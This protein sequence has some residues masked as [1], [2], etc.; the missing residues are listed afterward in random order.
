MVEK[1]TFKKYLPLES[2][3]K[4]VFSLVI[5]QLGVAF[6]MDWRAKEDTVWKASKN[7]GA[8]LCGCWLYIIIA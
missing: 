2:G 4:N 3:F 8:K 6:V 1:R 7:H 5:K